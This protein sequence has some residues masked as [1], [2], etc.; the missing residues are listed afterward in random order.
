MP[1]L[2]G[3]GGDCR[4]TLRCRGSEGRKERF[5]LITMP[6]VAFVLECLLL[7]TLAALTMNGAVRVAG[8]QPGALSWSYGCGDG[9]CIAP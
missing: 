8:K 1:H 7:H 3:C 9:S 6:R 4:D 2:S 5:I